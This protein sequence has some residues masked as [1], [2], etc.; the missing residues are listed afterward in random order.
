LD[1]E[2]IRRRFKKGRGRKETIIA[3]IRKE[4]I[5]YSSGF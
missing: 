2:K 1:E 3:R 5:V 4:K